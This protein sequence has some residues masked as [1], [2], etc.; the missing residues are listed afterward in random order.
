MAAEDL[1]SYKP[2]WNA[3]QAKTSV[4]S[5]GMHE[6]AAN[7]LWINAVPPTDGDAGV[8]A[9]DPLYWPHVEE[10]ADICCGVKADQR[11][12]LHA[13]SQGA[14]ARLMFPTTLY[15]HV[16]SL[17]DVEKAAFDSNLRLLTGH[18]QVA[19]WYWAVFFALE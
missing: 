14:V 3:V 2:P 13:S 18:L 16:E 8:I 4:Q 1:A 12:H 5:T 19:A 15:V 9:G 10:A 7:L 11:G 6:A 17:D